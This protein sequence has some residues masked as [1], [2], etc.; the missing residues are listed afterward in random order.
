MKKLFIL[1]S[2]ILASATFTACTCPMAAGSD[3]ACP[4]T[5]KACPAA[6]AACAVPTLTKEMFYD[7]DGKFNQEAAKQAYF[8]MMTRLGYPISDNLRQN[9][10]VSD[11]N[12]KDFP[13]VGM[14]GI[15]WAAD[16]KT[17]VFGHEI[18]LLPNQ[19]LVE[20]WHVAVPEKKMPAKNECWQA[21][22][23]STYCFGEEGEDASKFPNVKVPESQKNFVTVNK[24]NLACAKKGNVVWLNR[25]EARHFQ[26]AGPQ[27]AVV[28][29]YGAF[30]SGDGLKFTNPKV[31]F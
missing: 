22:A 27:G 5:A 8:D 29:E 2:A 31:A 4:K 12:L 7:K 15:F 20:H 23:G 11:F 10:W 26:I 3:T 24:A 1:A 17:G 18:F 30:H 9:M 13:N 19:L 6:K 14:G 16:D 25:L 28:T 21:K